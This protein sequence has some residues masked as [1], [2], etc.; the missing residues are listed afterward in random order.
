MSF[1]RVAAGLNQLNI[2][3]KRLFDLKGSRGGVRECFDSL[4]FGFTDSETDQSAAR[5]RDGGVEVRN[6]NYSLDISLL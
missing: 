1:W 5:H 6:N 3:L 2:P 4:I